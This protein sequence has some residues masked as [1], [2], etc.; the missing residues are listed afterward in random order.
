MVRTIEIADRKVPFDW[1]RL[2]SLLVGGSWVLRG[3]H[4]L[5][6]H[7]PKGLPGAFAALLANVILALPMAAIWF[8][9]D[10]AEGALAALVRFLGWILLLILTYGRIGILLW[11]GPR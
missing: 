10:L 6:Y 1:H 7:T 4:T 8:A 2:A 9:D 11:L 3:A 5:S